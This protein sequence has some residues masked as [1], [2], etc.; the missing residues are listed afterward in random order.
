MKQP[1]EERRAD[2]GGDHA[3]GDTDG[4]GNRIGEQ[5]EECSADRR[6]G[7]HGTRVRANGEACQVRHNETD[8]TDQAGIIRRPTG[9]PTPP[10]G[11]AGHP[12]RKYNTFLL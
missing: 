1:E 2:Q 8:E 4:A 9:R 5:Q 6:E 11:Q 3:N 7:Q 12:F 10:V